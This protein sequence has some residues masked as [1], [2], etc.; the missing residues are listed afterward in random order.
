MASSSKGT[1]F[2]PIMVGLILLL[3]AAGFYYMTRV[4]IPDGQGKKQVFDMET[5]RL[6]TVDIDADLPRHTLD[7]IAINSADIKDKFKDIEETNSESNKQMREMAQTLKQLND[8]NQSLKQQLEQ[9]NRKMSSVESAINN[10]PARTVDAETIKASVLGV[11]ER[12]LPD[13]MKKTPLG[14]LSTEGNSG[15]GEYHISEKQNIHNPDVRTRVRSYGLP[16]YDAKQQGKRTPVSGNSARPNTR[17]G[18]GTTRLDSR[19]NATSIQS[20]E[21]DVDPR[22]TIPSDAVL[23]DAITITALIGRIPRDNDVNDPAPFKVAIGRDNLAANGFSIPGIDGMIMSGTVY[24]DA[25]RKCVRTKITRAT[26][27]FEDGRILSLPNKRGKGKT[28][29]YLSD[30]YGDPCIKGRYF[31][32]G[33]TQL[34]KSILA[35]MAAGAANAYAETQVTSQTNNVGGTTRSVT[36]DNK[37]FVIGS[38]ISNGANS[39]ASLLASQQFDQWDQ[40]V[41]NVGQ[42]VVIHIDEQLEI[43]NASNLRKLVYEKANAAYGLTD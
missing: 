8:T 38:A 28:I 17:T 27:I 25:V 31:S 18:T 5:K 32:N 39:V 7:T 35:N 43:D 41:V 15:D 20:P 11:L 4:G 33:N 37:K 13:L 2:L 3:A 26:Y 1:K 14:T 16:A 21:R 10:Q 40:V 24:G 29:G 34:T 22:F 36:G 19:N 9:Q 30:P 42:S 12:N 6:K 23:N